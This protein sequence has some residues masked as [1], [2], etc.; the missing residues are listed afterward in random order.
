MHLSLC[1]LDGL[2]LFY[3]RLGVCLVAKKPQRSKS[4]KLFNL[5]VLTMNVGGIILAYKVTLAWKIIIQIIKVAHK[6]YGGQLIPW[7]PGFM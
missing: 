4:S 3:P 6:I 1:K 2:C 5:V 7:T